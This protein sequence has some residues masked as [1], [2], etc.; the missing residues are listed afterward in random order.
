MAEKYDFIEGR[1]G[2][3]LMQGLVCKGPVGDTINKAMEN[4]LILISAGAN[5]IRLVPPLVITKENV[6]EMTAIL[7]TCLPA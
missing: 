5:I 6:D 4:G 2:T 1:R 3:G 7:E